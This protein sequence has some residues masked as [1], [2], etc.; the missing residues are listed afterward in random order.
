MS[1]YVLA[2]QVHLPGKANDFTGGANTFVVTFLDIT[3][4]ET[5][6]KIAESIMDYEHKHANKGWLVGATLYCGKCV[7]KNFP[8]S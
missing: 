6:I 2:G 8:S 3:D 7:V 1:E 5:A 4:D